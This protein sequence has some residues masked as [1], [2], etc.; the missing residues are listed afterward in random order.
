MTKDPVTGAT[1]DVRFKVRS[2]DNHLRRE[3]MHTTARSSRE[4]RGATAS[5]AVVVLALLGLLSTC[6]SNGG[7]RSDTDDGGTGTGGS[8]GSV[9]ADPVEWDDRGLPDGRDGTAVPW[10]EIEAGWTLAAYDPGVVEDA[11][12]AGLFLIAPDG[13][14][15]AVTTVDLNERDDVGV[16]DWLP[17]PPQAIVAHRHLTGIDENPQPGGLD[18]VDLE[19]GQLR[20]LT[21]IHA[22]QANIATLSRPTGRVVVFAEGVGGPLQRRS[23]DFE[24]L[25]T[26]AEEAFDWVHSPD[27]GLVAVGTLPST[28]LSRLTVNANDTGAELIEMP[29]PSAFRFCHPLGWWDAVTLSASCGNTGVV[30]PAIL[31]QFPLDGAPPQQL[32]TAEGSAVTRAAQQPDGTWLLATTDGALW[33]AGDEG[34]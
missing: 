20:T 25:S 27:G 12:T 31:W 13:R 33:T 11:R 22:V 26:L 19:T 15:W 8:S 28:G 32:L 6:T 3:T 30:Q 18:L 34:T 7:T 29:V 2:G 14:R 23:S 4:H 16:E 17:N 9:A 5:L 10:D 1:G 21:A 24:L